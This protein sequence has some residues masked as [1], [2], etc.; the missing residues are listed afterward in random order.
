[1]GSKLLPGHPPQT[2]SVKM[3]APDIKVENI[4]GMAGELIQLS[5]GEAIF[6]QLKTKVKILLVLQNLFPSYQE[7]ESR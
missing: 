3:S 6:L 5:H 2:T 4:T 1:M 7:C